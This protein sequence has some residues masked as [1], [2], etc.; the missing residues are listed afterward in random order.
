METYPELNPAE[1][2]PVT[3]SIPT[4]GM[5]TSLQVNA[6]EDAPEV[7]SAAPAEEENATAWV[8]LPPGFD[9][10]SLEEKVDA[11]Q[12]QIA[13]VD[14]EV[15]QTEAEVALDEGPLDLADLQNKRLGYA[16]EGLGLDG[17]IDVEADEE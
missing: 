10:A 4:D 2:K 3:E 11:M 16:A 15:T 7:Q 12:E 9:E 13:S 1:E 8:D 6:A 17:L 14:D 5:D